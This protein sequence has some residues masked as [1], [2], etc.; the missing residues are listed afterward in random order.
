MDQE[1][2]GSSEVWSAPLWSVRDLQTRV[3]PG[4]SLVFFGEQTCKLQ[5]LVQSFQFSEDTKSLTPPVSLP[6]PSVTPPLVVPWS[7]PGLDIRDDQNQ[8]QPQRGPQQPPPHPSRASGS[9]CGPNTRSCTQ[10]HLKQEVSHHGVKLEKIRSRQKIQSPPAQSSDVLPAAASHKQSR[11]PASDP[12]IARL[13]GPNGR[14]P[15][16]AC[17]NE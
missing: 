10:K 8:Q 13:L 16:T 7:P 11:A 5:T 3:R 15:D 14:F 6:L 4:S 2:D 17:V 9:G 12:H 1:P